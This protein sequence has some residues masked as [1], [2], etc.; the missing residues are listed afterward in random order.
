MVG[1]LTVVAVMALAATASVGAMTTRLDAETRT[2]VATAAMVLWAWWGFATRNITRMGDT[3]TVSE[4]Y[5]G[6]SYLGFAF[7]LI[8]LLFVVQMALATLTSDSTE[9]FE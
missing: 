6:L 4:A 9:L 2:V 5:V 3:A 8:M 1:Q 7:A